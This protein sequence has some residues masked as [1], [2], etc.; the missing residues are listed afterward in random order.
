MKTLYKPLGMVISVLGGLAAN[1][2]FT[3]VW[4]R[5]SGE[6][7]APTSTARDYSWR[8][9]LFAAALQGAIFGLVKAAIDRAGATG[10]ESLT[11]TWP[12]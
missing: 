4:S 7:Q 9:V 12:E 11:G 10:Y 8:E 2:V 3:R 5:I 1:A 6:Q